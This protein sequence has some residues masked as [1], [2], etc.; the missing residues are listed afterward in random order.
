MAKRYSTYTSEELESAIDESREAA[1][2]WQDAYIQAVADGSRRTGY[3]RDTKR[4][5]WKK[6]YRLRDEKCFR[7]L[8]EA[9]CTCDPPKLP[10]RYSP[11]N[12]IICTKCGKRAAWRSLT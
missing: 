4:T 2:Y 5:K 8:H 3:L 12:T 11:P 6:F 1:L 7:L 10:T 9:G